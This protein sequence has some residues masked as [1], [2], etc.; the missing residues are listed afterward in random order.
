MNKKPILVASGAPDTTQKIKS[1]LGGDYRVETVEN[2]QELLD[3]F[4]RKRY[5]FTFIDVDLLQVNKASNPLNGFNEA[6]RPFRQTFPGAIIVVMTPPERIREAVAAVK[7]GAGDYLTYPLDMEEIKYVVQSL[8][9]SV[10][11]Q[12]EL[13]YLRDRFWLTDSFEIAKTNSDLMRDVYEKVRKVAPTKSTVLLTGDTGTGKTLLAKLIHSLSARSDQQFIAVHCGA[14]PD[15][16]IESELFGHEKGAFTGAV[17]KKAGKFEIAMGG[18]IFLDEVGTITQPAQIKMLQ[19]LQD[20]TF[21]RVGGEGTI[22]TDVRI[23]AASNEN[24]EEMSLNGQ[25]RRDL[26]YRLKVFPIEIPSLADRKEDIPLLIDIFLK[27][28]N[29]EYLKEIK[30][31]HSE[32]MEALVRYEWPGNVRELENI[33]ERA[34]I[35]ESSDRI[36][37]ESLPN[38]FCSQESN[39]SLPY[40]DS[41]LTLAA[42]R[43]KAVDYIEAHYLRKILAE[44]KGSINNSARHAGISTRQLHKLMTKYGLHKESFK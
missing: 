13:D 34:F 18:T 42:T 39:A 32:V 33:I 38:E 4:R 40:L 16:L 29:K 41:A 35:I 25:F 14:I 21:Q 31:V 37:L 6:L 19:V 36:S 10:L 9:E 1:C 20:R 22:E 43:Q 12:S 11:M 23:I 24:L 27:K 8:Y 26:F 5:E 30:G 17:R 44:H 7:A 3:R 2:R 15:N 28:L